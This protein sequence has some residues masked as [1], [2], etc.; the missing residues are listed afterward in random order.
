MIT[1]ITS[2]TL[3]LAEKTPEAPDVSK[4]A[5]KEEFR[6]VFHQFVGATLYGQMLKSM[7]Q[8]QQKTPYFDGGRAE[9][10][11]QQQL[12]QQLVDRV[13]EASSRTVSDPMFKLITMRSK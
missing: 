1:P 9:E 2:S 13:T 3:P 5:D 8:T 12:D 7:R 6:K 11:F 10:I 4:N